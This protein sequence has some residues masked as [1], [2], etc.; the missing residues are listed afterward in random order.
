MFRVFICLFF[1]LSNQSYVSGK[2]PIT[3]LIME[4][5]LLKRKFL[6]KL[7]WHTGRYFS[8][9]PTIQ[10]HHNLGNTHYKEKDLMKQLKD[11]FK[12][13]KNQTIKKSETQSVSQYGKCIYATKGIC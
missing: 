5:S 11:F 7:K 8:E 3:T 10:K 9:T 13:K 12:H 6:M 4:I 1:I 2:I